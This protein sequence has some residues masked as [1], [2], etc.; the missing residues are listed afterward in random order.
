METTLKTDI[1]VKD[2]NGIRAHLTL[3]TIEKIAQSLGVTSD[4]LLK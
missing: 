3:A 1:I 2:E 4:E